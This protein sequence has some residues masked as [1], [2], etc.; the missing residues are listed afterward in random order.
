MREHDVEVATT[1]V[2]DRH[3][4]AELLRRGWALGGEQSGHLIDTGFVPAGDGTAAALLVLEALA[5]GDLADRGAMQKLPQRLINVRVSDR[6]SIE[7][8]DEVWK[9]VDAAST[10]LEGR[11][12]VLVR[13]SGTE[14]LIRVMVEAPDEDECEEIAQELAK[15]VES[16]LR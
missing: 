5:G 13:S 1:P 9:A 3:V 7:D 16:C 10:R 6:G 14:P 4:L 12:R 11:G 15:T 8:A 2:G